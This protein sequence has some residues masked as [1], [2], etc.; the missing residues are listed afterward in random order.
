[1]ARSRILATPAAGETAAAQARI[2]GPGTLPPTSIDRDF[3]QTRRNWRH[4]K[5]DQ[6]L[7]ELTE[8][9]RQH[10]IIEPLVVTALGGGRYLL[11]AG[12]RRYVAAQRAGLTEAPVTIVDASEEQRTALQI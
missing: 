3:P 9:I 6:R 8:S 2:T 1:M 5:C 7:N 12:H 11:I 10:G 4:A